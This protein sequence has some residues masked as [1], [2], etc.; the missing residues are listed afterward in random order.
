MPGLPD[1]STAVVDV[2]DVV[3]LHLRAMTAPEAAGRRFIAAAGDAAPFAYIAATLRERLGE[4][5]HRVPRRRLP[6][7]LV[8]A[9]AAQARTLL[10]WQPR[11]TASGPPAMARAGPHRQPP[12]DVRQHLR[13]TP[14]NT[15]SSA[16]APRPQRLALLTPGRAD[17]ETPSTER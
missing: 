12:R 11:S 6:S 13:P 4:G 5:A 3:D 7:L 10:G 1:L 14:A 8:R 16:Q 15:P 9:D 2:R 17:R